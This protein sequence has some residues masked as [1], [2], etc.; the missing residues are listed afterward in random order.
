MS[1]EVNKNNDSLKINKSKNKDFLNIKKKKKENLSNIIAPKNSSINENIFNNEVATTLEKKNIKNIDFITKVK[2]FFKSEFYFFLK[3]YLYYIVLLAICFYILLYINVKS[4]DRTVLIETKIFS[5][6]IIFYIILMINDILKT[7]QKEQ[8]KLL[9]IIFISLIIV[10]IMN[11]LIEHFFKK[12]GFNSKLQ[13]VFICS[14]IIFIITSIIISYTLQNENN[15]DMTELYS[16]INFVL[17]KNLFFLI[18]IFIYLFIYKSVFSYLNDWNSSL[19][20]ILAPSLLGLLLIFFIFT[21]IINLLI[22]MRIISRIQILNGYIAISTISVFLVVVYISIFM[23]SL[24]TVCETKVS[25]E[26]LQK[27]EMISLLLCASIFAILWLDDTRNWHA[28]GSAVFLL[29]TVFAYYTLFYYSTTHPNIG[30]LSLWLF[31]EWMIIIFYKKENSKN[32]I[33]FVFMNV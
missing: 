21:F 19:S 3:N 2:N 20:D 28:I 1:K 30:G 14:L 12:D 23:S 4:N 24:S 32:S 29:I 33:H 17:N 27:E 9:S 22:K 5:Y 6:M 16:N 25:V 18:F 26:D 8:K 10:Y 13:K 7:P 31:I 11:K 15:K